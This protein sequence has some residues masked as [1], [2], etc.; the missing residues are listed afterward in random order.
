MKIV[1]LD[2]STEAC[3]VALLCGG[4]SI[5]RYIVE[6]RMHARKLLPMLDE[7]LA[8]AEL[9][10]MQLDGVAF[11]R[12]PGAFTGVRIGTAAAQ[13][14][15]LA[16][17]IPALPVSTLAAIAARAAREHSFTKIAVAIDAR[18]DEVYWGA[19]RHAGTQL[20][21]M[22]EEV[23]CPAADVAVLDDSWV[24]AGTGWATYGSELQAVSGAFS[25]DQAAD[26]PHA[27]DVLS[28]G[29]RMFEN[30]E[31]VAAESALPVY[32]RNKVAKTEAER[33]I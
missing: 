3:S 10:P 2:T 31:G 24:G 1:A 25:V 13:A 22:G 19:Y 17:D 9:R 16:A 18:M 5:S 23:V 15:A 7:L 26:F 11:T 28:I 30:G 6:P 20:E 32:L 8:E 29:V 27:L 21:L 4:N 33:K 14:I 12:G